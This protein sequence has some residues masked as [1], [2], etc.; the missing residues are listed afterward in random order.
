[1]QIDRTKLYRFPWSKTDNPR[2]WVEVTD[3][4]NMVCPGCYRSPLSGHRPLEEVKQ[5]ILDTRRLTNCDCMTIAGGEPLIYP[6]LKE[7]VKFISDL[8]L[9]PVLFTNGEGL[10]PGSL[11]ELKKAGLVNI[12][13]HIDKLQ[14]RT[15]WTGKSESEINTL[16]EY[17]ADMLYDAGGIQCG[18]HVTIYRSNLEEIP[19]IV[20]WALKNIHKVQHISFI[21]YRAIPGNTNLQFYANGKKV[22]TSEL[23]LLET[24]NYQITISTEEM[25]SKM[26]EVYPELRPATY[27]NGT[28]DYES[29]KFLITVNIGSRGRRY[30]MMGARTM[31]MAQVFYHLF[32]GRYFVFLKSPKAGTK[33]FIMSLFDRDI[34]KAARKY[35]AACIRNPLR[36]FQGI[37]VQSIHFQQPNEV[38][39]GEINLCDDCVNMMAYKGKLINPCRLDEYRKYGDSLHIVKADA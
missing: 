33:L 23:S 1:M 27:L 31:E 22:E 29:N 11:A 25:Y 18:Y 24:D 39:N 37:Y 14:E 20:G 8:K 38:I 13:F 36:L 12:H 30:G 3:E 26:N 10:D 32:H 15:G 17:Y 28:S 9:K 4:C 2:G 6:H 35:L 19:E 5:D 16:R 34:R 21:A 7:V